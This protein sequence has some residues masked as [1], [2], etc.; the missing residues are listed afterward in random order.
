VSRN[1]PAPTA[2]LVY[3]TVS[4]AATP[5]SDYT[6]LS[7]SVT[8]A[9]GQSAATLTVT[10]VND[11]FIEGPETVVLTL[12]ANSAYT[13]G[14]PRSATV[15]ITSEDL[16]V[17]TLRAPEPTAMESPLATGSFRISRTG[18]TTGSLTV[19][20]TRS[21]TAT[22]GSDYVNFP[23][24]LTIPAGQSAATITVTPIDDTLVEDSETLILTL[25][26]SAGYV[27]GT[28]TTATVTIFSDDFMSSV[29]ST[30]TSGGRRFR[31][32]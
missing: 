32:H 15:T 26:P 23:L 16:P 12:K 28:P 20:F 19:T 2:L 30:G 3:Y 18:P 9:A 7:G 8:I 10:P 13:V 14:S 1:A 11:T 21:G 29:G 17:V 24:S 22:P 4:G 6:V 27:V 25:S 5:G 31:I